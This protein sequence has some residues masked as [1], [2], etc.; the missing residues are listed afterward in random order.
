[1]RRR[2]SL[3]PAFQGRAP[4]RK[5][6]RRMRTSTDGLLFSEMTAQVEEPCWLAAAQRGDTRALERL[7]QTYHR[8]VYA[9]CYRIVCRAEDAEDATQA[10]FVGAFRGLAKFRGQSSLKTWI[11]RIAVNESLNL[12]RQ[13][14]STP[15]FLDDDAVFCDHGRGIVEKEAVHAILRQM[16]PEQ[17]LILILFYWEELSCDEIAQVV[18]ISLS[19]AKMRLKRAREEFQTRYGVEP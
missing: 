1:V 4:R 18:D 9:L 16:R 10:T 6:Q 11:Y 3:N 12:L 8:A 14:R 17:R 2:E 13:R 15:M 19:A 5:H 7:F